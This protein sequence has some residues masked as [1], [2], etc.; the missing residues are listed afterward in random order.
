MQSIRLGRTGLVV[1]RVG[2]G[3]IPIQRLSD[4]DAVAVIRTCLE[5]GMTY[6]DTANAYST[7]EGRIGRALKEWKKAVVIST[8]TQSRTAEGV[9]AHLAQSLKMLQVDSIDLYQFH[10]VSSFP[11]LEKILDPKGTH[12]GGAGGHPGRQGQ[13]HGHHLAPDRCGEGD[14][15]VGAI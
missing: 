12:P 8:K 10:N 9:A 5:R 3:S 4:D 6:I 7:S 15:E 13:A 14:G 11:E 2:F 1:S